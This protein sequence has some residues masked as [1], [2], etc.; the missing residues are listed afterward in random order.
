M[1]LVKTSY[2]TLDL[3]HILSKQ[4]KK[5]ILDASAAMHVNEYNVILSPEQI[6]ILQELRSHLQIIGEAATK[7]MSCSRQLL[8]SKYNSGRLECLQLNVSS[9]VQGIIN[10]VYII[11]GDKPYFKENMKA[12]FSLC[13][14]VF[15][16]LK[17]TRWYLKFIQ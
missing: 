3:K 17:E 12:Y 6:S 7:K 8:I 4:D 1:A 14:K 5:E 10:I 16:N 15:S 13:L 9:L 2:K 11:F